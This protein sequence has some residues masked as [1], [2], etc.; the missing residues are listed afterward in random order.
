MV[1]RASVG[2]HAGT[3]MKTGVK[4]TSLEKKLAQFGKGRSNSRRPGK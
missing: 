4:W 3:H 2:K 1:D